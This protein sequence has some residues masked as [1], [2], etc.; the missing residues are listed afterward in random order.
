MDA[1]FVA[2]GFDPVSFALGMGTASLIW[3]SVISFL[4]WYLNR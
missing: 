1:W 3:L 4:Q 2:H